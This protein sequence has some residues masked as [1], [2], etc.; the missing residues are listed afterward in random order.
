MAVRWAVANGNWSNTATWDGGT[1][2]TS[3]DDVHANGQTV[4]IDQNITVLTLRT[5]ARSGGVAGGGFVAN[6]GV[7]IN[8]TNV[9]GAQP[10]GIIPGS[11]PV[12]SLATGANVTLNSSI[13]VSSTTGIYAVSYSTGSLTLNG[14]IH[15][16][17]TQA[18]IARFAGGVLVQTTGSITATGTVHG[19]YDARGIYFASTGS[20]SVTGD[21]LGAT[22]GISASAGHAVEIATSVPSSVSIVG[23]VRGRSVSTSSANGG[24]GFFCTVAASNMTITGEVRS[25]SNSQNAGA[26][27]TNGQLTIIG[28]IQCDGLVPALT[29][30]GNN[31]SNLI[32]VT[33][34]FVT[35]TI[36]FVVPFY[37]FRLR[38]SPT[39]NKY[40]EFR[41]TTGTNGNA[42][43]WYSADVVADSPAPA[44]VRL[45]TTYASGS[46]TGTCAV[47]PAASVAAGVPVGNT[48]GTAALSP[49]DVAALVGAQVAAAMTAAP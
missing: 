6:D 17:A 14:T 5:T 27:L 23:N 10:G 30:S 35:N 13:A 47:P 29:A 34:P 22:N 45:G 12:L 26:T 39:T 31:V 3:A 16:T 4:T 48:T 46:L 15:G 33:G 38:L 44:N 20:I 25:Q 8:A 11:T 28:L 49:A 9:S 19:S 32:T 18:S 7:T 2:P 43:R 24:C 42:V 36:G 1:L 21:C 37:V 41:D 40:Y